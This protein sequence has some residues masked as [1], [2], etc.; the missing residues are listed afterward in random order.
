LRLIRDSGVVIVDVFDGMDQAL[1]ILGSSG[2]GKTTLL[3]ELEGEPG[4]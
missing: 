2:S 1:L 3:L 4:V